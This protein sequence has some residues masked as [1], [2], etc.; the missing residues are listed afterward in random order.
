MLQVGLELPEP[1]Q[2]RLLELSLTP[3]EL[4]AL[5]VLQAS[6]RVSQGYHIQTVVCC[7]C[8][9]EHVLHACLGQ[10]LRITTITTKLAQSGLGTPH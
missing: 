7:F 8:M 6:T 5:A 9:C 10:L 2:G 4:R 3:D 1:Q